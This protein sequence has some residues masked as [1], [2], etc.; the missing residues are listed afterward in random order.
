MLMCAAAP[1]GGGRSELTPRFMRFFNVFNL[2]EPSYG[3]LSTIFGSILGGFLDNGMTDPVKKMGDSVV[4]STI[5]I[6]FRILQTL[7]PTPTKFHYVFNLRDVSKV[8]QGILMAS[9]RSLPTA[10]H[11]AKI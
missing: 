3:T 9:A 2:P 7:K 5:E 1:P 6:Y 11:L 10:D 4:G 8:F